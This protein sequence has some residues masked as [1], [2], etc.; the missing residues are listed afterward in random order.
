MRG[1][2]IK[3]INLNMCVLLSLKKL[4]S[5]AQRMRKYLEKEKN[6]PKNV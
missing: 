6:A 4:I 3:S 2:Q 5:H 1:S